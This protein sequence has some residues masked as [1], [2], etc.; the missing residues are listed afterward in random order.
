M[1]AHGWLDAFLVVEENEFFAR[2]K[3]GTIWGTIY[4]QIG[5]SQFFPD[6]GW[7]DMVAAFVAVWLEALIR[8]TNGTV[9]NER[10]HFFDGPFAVDFSV[11]QK[12][13][14]NLTFLHNEEPK[15][16]TMA[17]VQQLRAH[18][19]SVGQDLLSACQR[20]GWSDRD[21]QTIASLVQQM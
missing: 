1:N 2:S 17:E 18:A 14:V 20:R 3:S 9:A 7:T 21:T 4:F 10:V 5:D 13:Q 12:G 6:K 11:S 15:L 8:V 19:V 16:S